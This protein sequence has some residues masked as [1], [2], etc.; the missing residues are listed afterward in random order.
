MTDPHKMTKIYI[1]I[2]LLPQLFYM[3]VHGRE[4]P[5]PEYFKYITKSETNETTG[6]IEI[7][8]PQ[9]TGVEL[10]LNLTLEVAGNLPTVSFLY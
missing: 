5:C 6:L 8:C 1:L 4:S 7:S 10:Q 3:L 9:R 2:A